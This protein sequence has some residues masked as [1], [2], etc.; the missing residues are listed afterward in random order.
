MEIKY[1]ISP[2]TGGPALCRAKFKPCQYEHFSSEAEAYEA[3]EH[4]ALKE[5]GGMVPESQSREPTPAPP[6]GEIR[7]ADE[8]KSDSYHYQELWLRD[9][10]GNPTVYV[11]VN[12]MSW[13]PLSDGAYG[14]RPGVVLCDVEINPDARGKGYALST[15][16]KLK[17]TYGAE[18][19]EF[20]GSFSEAGYAM[21]RK[22]QAEEARTGERLVS[23]IH[24]G[25]ITEPYEGQSYSFVRDWA[26]EHAKYRL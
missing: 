9:E 4:N 3:I 14:M 1:H 11:K 6:L 25:R 7:V 17:E 10:A 12:L 8:L 15:I 13:G 21:F 5:A 20:T 2:K 24:G 18:S 22:L 23:I 19:V 16:R 26:T